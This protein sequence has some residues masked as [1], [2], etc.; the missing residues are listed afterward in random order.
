MIQIQIKGVRRDGSR[1]GVVLAVRRGS[2]VEEFEHDVDCATADAIEA[3]L[4]EKPFEPRKPGQYSYEIETVTEGGG[5][6]YSATIRIRKGRARLRRNIPCSKSLFLLV[7]NILFHRS[8][9]SEFPETKRL[10]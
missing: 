4:A 1:A 7:W 3:V 10:T 2:D 8:L 9:P 5:K 6:P